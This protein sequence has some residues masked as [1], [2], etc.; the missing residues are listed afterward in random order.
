MSNPKLIVSDVTLRDGNHAVAQ[1]LDFR[2][3][4]KFLHM[5]DESGVDW[6]EIGHGNGLGASSANFG[7]SAIEDEEM[8][9]ICRSEIKRAKVA[10]HVMP[11]IATFSKNV[12]PAIEL[13]VDV[14]RVGAHCTEADTTQRMIEKIKDSDRGVFGVLMM[15]HRINPLELQA[16]AKKMFEAGAVGVVLMDSAGALNDKSVKE[17]VDALAQLQ[18]GRV[19]FHAHNNLGVAISNSLVAIE[20]GATVIDATALGFGA[21]AGNAAMEQLFSHLIKARRVDNVNF[22]KYS[23]AIEE[24]EKSLG[25]KAPKVSTLSILTGSLGIFSGFAR[26]IESAAQLFHVN[27][28]DICEELSHFDTVAGQEDLIFEVAERLANKET[29]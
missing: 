18:L 21:G 8:I 10:V 27:K 26:Q 22:D 2:H 17:R 13:G 6:I 29:R 4:K 24:G 15:V 12:K 19:G 7:Y 16:Q 11:G 20:S 5:I 28:S 25:L 1:K 14:F 3:A 23:L 9:E